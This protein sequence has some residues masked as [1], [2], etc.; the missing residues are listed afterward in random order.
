M[1]Y[2]SVSLKEFKKKRN[3]IGFHNINIQCVV[4][5]QSLSLWMYTLH[6][7]TCYG[8][9]DNFHKTRQLDMG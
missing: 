6:F 5:N 9:V 3:S 7:S 4:V 1:V 8:H 2:R